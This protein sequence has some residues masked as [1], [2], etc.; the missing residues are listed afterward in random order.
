MIIEYAGLCY[1]ELNPCKKYNFLSLMQVFK[2]RKYSCKSEF[3]LNVHNQDDQFLHWSPFM[4]ILWSR[5][6]TL[7]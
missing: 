3:V 5:N 1:Q 4:H 7:F 2:E 6:I